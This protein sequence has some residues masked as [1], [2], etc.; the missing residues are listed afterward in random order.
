[1][2]LQK[3]LPFVAVATILTL[4]PDGRSQTT[5]ASSDGQVVEMSQFVVKGDSDTSYIASES[6]T[7]TRV[8]TQIKD[9]PF[10]VSVVTSE[11]MNDFDFFDIAS[12]MGY[13]AS[14]NSVDTQGNST[15]RGYGATFYLRNGFYR[16][17][18]VD[19][20][21]TDRVEIIKGP[22]AAIYGSTSPAGL[23]NIVT[24][25]P[26]FTPY[27]KLI[28]T[29]GSLHMWRAEFNV[30]TPLGTLGGVQFAQ[31]FSARAQNNLYETPYAMNRNRLIDY[32]LLAKFK[33][34]ST[35]DFEI[36]WSKRKAVPNTGQIPFGYNA[37]TKTY[38]SVQYKNL[39][40]FSQ[41]GPN[42]VANREL[43]S[44]YLTYDKTWNRTWSTH[45]GGN[46]YFRHA[47]NFNN[48][49]K[50]Q[51]DPSTG[52]IPHS[53]VITDPLNED[54]GAV[55]VDT[56]ARYPLFNG[57][58]QNKTLL[59]LDYSQNWRYRQQA[60][61]NSTVWKLPD[62]LVVNP[63][64][65]VPPPSAYTIVTRSDKV[66]WDIKGLLL[67]QQSTML[68]DR[69]IV[70]GDVRRDIVTYNLNFGNQ[71]NTGGKNP[72]S[73]KTAGQVLHYTDTAWSPAFGMN[74]KVTPGIAIYASHSQSFSPQGQVAKLGTPHL[75]NETSVGWDYGVKCSFLDDRLVFTAGGYYIDRFHVKATVTDPE[76][77]L[78]ES[79]AAGT[80]VAKGVEFEGSWRVNNNLTILGSYSHVD[81]VIVYNGDAVTDVGQPP[82][83]V[84][85][86]QASLAWK[87]RVTSG[88]LKGWSWNTGVVYSGKAFPNSTA[89][90]ARRNVAAPGYATIDTGLTYTW[91]GARNTQQAIRVSARNLLDRSY[92]TNNGNLG[93]A[94]AF[95]V[96]FTLEH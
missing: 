96:A 82:P 62:I 34:A 28:L 35:L 8:A 32:N 83:G 25:T 9:L 29:G 59:T 61:F 88:P 31:L 69:L 81:A 14:L 30:N 91:K 3:G 39:A 13:T 48:G 37:K 75:E 80:Q 74:Y 65:A 21:N 15:L 90:D 51:Y 92:E 4:L 36:E 78:S 86:E 87:Y 5:P 6:V 71:Y 23:I 27:Q 54:G 63:N 22:N 46:L 56:L 66:R 95:Y 50:D 10:T 16:L 18:L 67:R 43:T 64:Y 26:K 19:R 41:S 7:G 57:K 40:N 77:G 79:V 38:S 47:R 76:T 1:M 11:F 12:S 24:K 85:V 70:F 33:D 42:A 72:G 93:D 68:H 89:T 49:S 20:V 58:V 45:A 73:L 60:G 44:L 53:S 2:I 94:R 55:Q 84:P 17:G 52:L